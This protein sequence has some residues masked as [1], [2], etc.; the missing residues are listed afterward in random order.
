MTKA[1]QKEGEEEVTR[2]QAEGNSIVHIETLNCAQRNT[3]QA[4]LENNQLRLLHTCSTWCFALHCTM[5]C[6]LDPELYSS[7]A[8]KEHRVRDCVCVSS[9]TREGEKIRRDTKEASRTDYRTLSP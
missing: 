5:P 1:A 6:C 9:A 4:G 7:R 2:R 8:R 3:A